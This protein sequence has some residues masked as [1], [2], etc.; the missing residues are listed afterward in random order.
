MSNYYYEEKTAYLT[1][2]ADVRTQDHDLTSF[3]VFGLKGVAR[4]SQRLFA[5]IRSNLSKALFKTMAYDL[6][7]RLESKRR[8]VIADRQLAV[9]EILL[10]DDSLELRELEERTDRFYRN[11]TDPYRAMI[12]DLNHLITL[13]AIRHAMPEPNRHV[14]SLN[15][16]W[17]M[18]IA[19]SEFFRRVAKMPRAKSHTLLS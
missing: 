5:E 12:R 6:F 10:R 7:K 18:Q 11:L 13:G 3:L 1:A 14:L 9:L 2:L 15:L 8:R 19:E 4:Q 16:D 17:P